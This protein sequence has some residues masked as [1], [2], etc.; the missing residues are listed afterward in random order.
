MKEFIAK[1]KTT[2]AGILIAVTVFL[3]ARGIIDA[4]TSILITSLLGA[5]GLAAAKDS[6]V[7][8]TYRRYKDKD[9]G[10][11]LSAPKEDD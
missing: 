7:H 10:S 4:D 6:D 2:I 9:K 11:P 1:N 5:L 3:K 8:T